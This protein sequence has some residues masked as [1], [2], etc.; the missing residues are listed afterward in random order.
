VGSSAS[1]EWGAKRRNAQ[2]AGFTEQSQA[3]DVTMLD[4]RYY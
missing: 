1:A 3:F 4:H 2:T